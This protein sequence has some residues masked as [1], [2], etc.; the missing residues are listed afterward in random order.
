[1]DDAPVI[2]I[3]MPA[4]NA[5]Q[6]IETAIRSVIAQTETSW[7]LIVVDDGSTDNTADIAE[8]CGDARVRVL[9][10][11]HS[12][13][14]AVV[15][16]QG[17]I[18][19]RG[20]LI[21]FLDAD[22]RWE[23][24]KLAYQYTY[25]QQY[26]QAGVIFS[27]YYV[28]FDHRRRPRSIEPHLRHVPN[29]GRLFR[30][31]WQQNVIGTSTALVRRSLLDQYGGFDEDPRLRGGEDYELWLRLALHTDFGYVDQPLS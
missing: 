6:F 19:A 8:A 3:I 7:E 23:P 5:A 10:L 14:P 11:Q 9:R 2:S 25:S 27:R 31:L 24:Q 1:M 13:L 17:L 21:A 18:A 4:Y 12:S 15:R 30:L 22:D 26:P 16:N 20:S 28:W 29:P